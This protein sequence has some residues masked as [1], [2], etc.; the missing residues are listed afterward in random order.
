M[1]SYAVPKEIREMKPA[2]TT[3]K[4]VGGHYYVYECRCLKGE[5]GKWHTKMGRVIGSIKEGIGFIPNESNMMDDEIS[6]LEYGQ[7]AI[8]IEN[9]RKALELLKEHFSAE[10]ATTIYT[11]A[12]IHFINGFTYMKDLKTIFD[13]SWMSHLWPEL[14][15]GYAHLGK[16]Y[17]AL[18]NRQTRV[19]AFEQDLIDNGSG[20]LA[21]DG[22]VIGSG[23]WCNDL[24]EKGYRFAELKEMQINMLMAYDVIHDIPV[25]VKTCQGGENDKTSV[26]DILNDI[27][28]RDKLL[29]VDRGFYSHRN[30][31]L[32]TEGGNSYIIPVPKGTAECKA[33]VA[34]LSYTGLFSYDETGKIAAIEYKECR[35]EDGST[36]YVFRDTCEAVKMESNYVHHIEMG[37]KGYTDE[38]FR[39]AKPFFGVYVLRT[40]SPSMSAK[41]VFSW[42]KKRWHIETFYNYFSNAEHC[43]AFCQQDYYRIQGLSFILLVSSI[44]HR[45]FANAVEEK[46]KRKKLTV[47]DVILASRMVKITKRGGRWICT[48]T[49]GSTK[50]LFNA[51]DTSLSPDFIT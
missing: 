3:V 12:M 39:K 11:C 44:I 16:L 46:M 4:I 51:L 28:L 45:E 14:K 31:S 27:S 47:Q 36:I 15:M 49:K 29:I 20:K 13:M 33:A 5:D 41:E 18:G 1:G 8:V 6:T 37:K 48:N 23:S 10:D 30:L 25:A 21:I 34:D 26:E 19:L 17:E 50:D 43:K 35:Q 42:Y 40:N 9:S 2:G 32:F 38:G 7:Y 22:H 24:A